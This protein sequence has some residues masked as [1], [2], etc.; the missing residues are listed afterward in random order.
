VAKEEMEVQ[1]VLEDALE[2]AA[3]EDKALM[4]VLQKLAV[5]ATEEMAVMVAVADM[6]VEVRAGHPLPCS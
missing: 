6:E 1:E 5:E 3:R 4:S 2:Q